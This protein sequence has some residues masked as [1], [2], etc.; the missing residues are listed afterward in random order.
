MK[1]FQ[2]NFGKTVVKL[3]V[4][5]WTEGKGNIMEKIVRRCK[6]KLLTTFLNVKD[7][8]KFSSHFSSL[9]SLHLPQISFRL[10]RITFKLLLNSF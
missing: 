5:S 2:K 8:S 10:S 9:I 1:L 6:K 4:K 3:P 7:F